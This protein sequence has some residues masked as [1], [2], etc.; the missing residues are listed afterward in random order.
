MKIGKGLSGAMTFVLMILLLPVGGFAESRMPLPDKPLLEAVKKDDVQAVRAALKT[1]GGQNEINH[2]GVT[3]DLPLVRAARNGNLEIVSLLVEHGA[4]IDIGKERGE[5]TPL[6]EAAGQGHVDVV[7]FLLSKGADVN[8]RG[9]GLTPLLLACAWG[10]L[11]AGPPGDKT[12]TIYILLENGA[13]VNVQDESWLKTG[14]TP[15]MYAVLQGDAA[16][17]QALLDRGARKDLKNKDGDT[18]LALARKSGLEYISQLLEKP[19]A[20]SK[21]VNP[22]VHPLFAAIKEGRPEAVKALI[23]KGADVNLRTETGSTPL[24]YAADR[25]QF[26]IVRILLLAGADVNAGN[27]ANNTALIYAS[28]KGHVSVV[29]ELLRKKADV[30]VK[31]LAKG[32]ALIYAVMGQKTPVV[33]VLLSSG[34]RVTDQY[35]DGKSALMMAVHDGSTD[36]A[37]LL[38]SHKADVNAADPNQMTALMMACEKGNAELVEALLKAGADIHRKSKYGD[39]ALGKAIAG[40][41]LPVVKILVKKGGYVDRQE[42][43]FSAVMNGNLEIVRLLLTKDADVNRRGF[44]GGTLLMLAVDKNLP[45]VKF[46]MARGADVQM[47]DDEG[48]TALMKAVRSFNADNLSITRYLLD[49]GAK[50]DAVNN[51]GETAL[52]LAAKNF[53]AEIVSVLVEKSSAASLSLKDQEGKSAWTYALQGDKPAMVSILE[54]AG[55]GG[56]YRGMEWKGNVS[57]QREPFI[58]VVGTKKEWSELWTRALEK[59]APDVDFE[60]YVVACIFLGHSARWLYSVGLGQP[61]KRGN[62]LVIEYELIDVMLRLAG[63]FKA[64]GQYYMKVFDKPKDIPMILE[65]AGPNSRRRR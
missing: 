11:P 5:R 65:E 4:I 10:N 16:L 18:A 35:D 22:D 62:E 17:V 29:R 44:G 41:H 57:R 42:A 28:I 32:D 13:D 50:V 34:A 37:R 2:S 8:A 1:A 3:G 19:A 40:H 63:P 12:K 48:E 53:H 31:N 38:I 51:R 23:A 43:L 27:G 64:G 45:L 52:I 15:L 14:R 58:K 54:K 24:M 33:K 60:K 7:K 20:Q 61:E 25:N 59:P 49:H 26:T 21:P 55:A 39:T 6:I 36:I 46:L 56:D 47:K 30:N 9:N